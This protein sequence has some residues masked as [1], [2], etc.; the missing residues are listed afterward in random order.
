MDIVQ[1]LST[2]QLYWD[3][4]G[5]GGNERVKAGIGWLRGAEGREREQ[6]SQGG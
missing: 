4:G 5:K 2:M 3:L 1:T 6:E